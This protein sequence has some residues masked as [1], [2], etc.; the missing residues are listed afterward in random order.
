[1]Y[2]VVKYMRGKVAKKLRKL[3]KAY[4]YTNPMYQTMKNI[5]IHM[6]HNKAEGFN[7][8]VDE[9]ILKRT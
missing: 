9:L 4:G 2:S 5:R 8:E 3:Q 6:D 7:R 1:M